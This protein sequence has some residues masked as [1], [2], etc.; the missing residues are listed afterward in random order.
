MVQQP[1]S[2]LDILR[3][4]GDH[5]QSFPL[6]WWSCLSTSW[7]DPDRTRFHDFNLAPTHLADLVDLSTAFADD[8]TDQIVRYVDLL[9]LQG[10]SC[11]CG[12]SRRRRH[13]GVRIGIRVV[14]SWGPTAGAGDR[15]LVGTRRARLAVGK[16][17]GAMGFLLL[18]E[19]IPNIIS[20]NMNGVRNP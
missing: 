12:C 19:N 7:T 9:R 15:V 20:R 10:P 18:D 14:R 6:V 16:S 1:D 5:D 11:S 17:D 3:L 4:T 8:T 2:H 13:G